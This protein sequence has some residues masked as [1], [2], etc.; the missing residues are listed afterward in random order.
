[1]IF[2]LESEPGWPSGVMF[3]TL[4]VLIKL[5]EVMLV[6]MVLIVFEVVLMFGLCACVL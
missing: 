1:M 4:I 3:E 6:V 5:W 2:N